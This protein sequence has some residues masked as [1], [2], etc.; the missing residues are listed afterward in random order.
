MTAITLLRFGKFSF[1]IF[2]SCVGCPAQN[3]E[4]D[5]SLIYGE[6]NYTAQIFC[7]CTLRYLWFCLPLTLHQ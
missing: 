5:S 3:V 6:Q 1:W 2:P 4:E 7:D